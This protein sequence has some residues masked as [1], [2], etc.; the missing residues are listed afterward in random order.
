MSEVTVGDVERVLDDERAALI[1]GDLPALA[2]IVERKEVLVRG[3]ASGEIPRARLAGL[4]A[5]AERNEEL[6]GAAAK[7]VRTVI[8]RVAEIRDANG[9]LKTYGRDGTQQMLGSAAS[10]LEKRA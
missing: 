5:R 9:P 3:L 8:R 1:A 4:K 6:L 7:G 10:S 2:E